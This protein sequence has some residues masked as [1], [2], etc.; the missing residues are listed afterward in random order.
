MQRQLLLH[1]QE[2]LEMNLPKIELE[3]LPEL[4][5]KTGVFGSVTSSG[6][7]GYSDDRVIA[8]MVYVYTSS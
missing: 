4:E 2:N 1:Q 8:I 7:G 3:Q 5:E 6:G